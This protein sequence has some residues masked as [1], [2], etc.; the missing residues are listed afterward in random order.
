MENAGLI[1][2]RKI[3]E[4]FSPSSACILA[5]PGNNGGDGY[6]IARHLLNSGLKVRI[7]SSVDPSNLKGDARTHYITAEKLGLEISV[8]REVSDNNIL[9]KINSSDL[10]IDCL[11]GTGSSGSPRGQIARLIS[12]T[13]TDSEVVSIDL[14]SGIDPDT[15]KVFEPA[16]S[17]SLTLTMLA[18]KVGL[19]VMPASKYT[20]VIETVCIGVDSRF[21]LNEQHSRALVAG[22]DE[23]RLAIPHRRNDIHKGDRGTLLILG[24]SSEYKG[25]SVL[26]SLSALYTGSG[27]VVSVGD[28]SVDR[29]LGT[30][31]PEVISYGIQTTDPSDYLREFEEYVCR[32]KD[33]ASVALIG[34]GLSRSPIRKQ[35]FIRIWDTWEKTLVVDGDGLFWLSELKRTLSIRKNTI[36]T[37]HEGEAARLAGVS[38]KEVKNN[39]LEIARELGL[40]WG[41]CI[42][43][44]PNT[45][46]DNGE[47]TVIIREGSPSLSV[48]GSGDVLA[49]CVASLAASGIPLFESAFAGAW[50]HGKCGN[51]VYNSIGVDGVLAR[52][53]A[54]TIPSVLTELRS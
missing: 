7:I 5:G 38:S 45:I 28:N 8:S 11:L 48:A 35:M 46:V 23:V 37:P 13:G 25:A 43:K 52:N 47:R 54:E 40:K 20:G 53:I 29:S 19:F 33:K 14:P 50:I 49:G 12:L 30:M 4:I 1:S 42:L 24:G 34:P 51:R 26:S 44:G 39:R 6:V 10:I 27:I 16:I 3:L 41:V 32:W 2:A 31:I 22:P 21:I 17:A 18:P 9:E 15:G 36:I